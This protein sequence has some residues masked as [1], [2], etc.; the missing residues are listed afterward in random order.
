MA[1]TTLFSSKTSNYVSATCRLHSTS[2]EMLKYC[3]AKQDKKWTALRN[4]LAKYSKSVGLTWYSFSALRATWMMAFAV[5][6]SSWHKESSSSVVSKTWAPQ[7]KPVTNVNTHSMGKTLQ[8][9]DG[10]KKLFQGK[11]PE[12][13]FFQIPHTIRLAWLSNNNKLQL[14]SLPASAT[15]YNC[16]IVSLLTRT[17]QTQDFKI[18]GEVPTLTYSQCLN[19]T[20]R[21]KTPAQWHAEFHS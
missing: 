7:R 19:F 8:T 17:P 14:T 9:C 20:R 11:T 13:Q 21:L 10:G 16:P 18:Q 15:I 3:I 12:R 1:I 6:A 2:K 4:S 5:A